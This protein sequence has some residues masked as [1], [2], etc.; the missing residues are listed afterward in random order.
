MTTTTAPPTRFRSAE[1]R[2]ARLGRPLR[3]FGHVPAAV[4]ERLMAR[5]GAALTER[6]EP[7]GRLAA[8]DPN[9]SGGSA[10]RDP[11]PVAGRPRRGTDV[12][13]DAPPA[14]R[15][16]LHTVT[17]VPA[18]TDWEL[19]QRGT[20][21]FAALGRNAADILLQLSLLGGYRFGGPA[22]LLVRTGGLTGRQTRRRLAETQHWAVSLASADALRPGGDGWRV[23]VHVRVMHA[24]VNAVHEP[25]WDVAGG[26]CRSTRP[27]RPG[28]WGSSTA[29]CCSGRGRSACRCHVPTRTRSCTCGATSGG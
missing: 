23:T 10:A 6:D 7:A 28:R 8:R 13:A 5:I 26:G 12:P 20:E 18:W 24:L 11:R 21:V 17:D 4:D 14:L 9:A 3:R 16:F 22:D 27:T 2:G 29:R 25:S 1:A 15:E 19:V